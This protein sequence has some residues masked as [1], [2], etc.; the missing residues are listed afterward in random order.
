MFFMAMYALKMSLKRQKGMVLIMTVKSNII[1][2]IKKIKNKKMVLVHS[3]F[4]RKNFS[5]ALLE[6][7]KNNPSTLSEFRNVGKRKDNKQFYHEVKKIENGYNL[8]YRDLMI[9]DKNDVPKVDEYSSIRNGNPLCHRPFSMCTEFVIKS[10]FR[11]DLY[12]YPPSIMGE[13][14]YKQHIVSYLE[15]EGFSLTKTE[16]YD[17]LGI[18]NILFTYSTT[19]AYSLIIRAIARP[20]D[21][22]LMSAPNYGIFAVT[23]EILNARVE[24]VNLREEDDWY[25]NPDLVSQRIDEINQQLE[26]QFKGVLEYTPKVVAFLNINPHNPVGKVLNRKK[27]DI[28]KKLSDI[29]LKKGVFIIDDLIYRDLTFDQSDLAFPIASIPTYFNNTISILGLSKAYG[30]AKAK[31]GVIV[32]PI[33]VC[34]KICDEFF[35]EMDSMSVFQAAAVAGAFN[36]TN[37]RYKKSKRYFKK[38]IREYQYHLHLLEALIYGIDYENISLDRK[39]IK[40]DIEKYT[41]DAK[42]L[43]IIFKGCPGTEIRKN[44]YPESGFFAIVDFTKLKGKKHKGK[45][46][47][48][49]ADFVTFLYETTKINCLMGLNFSW[50][51]EEE[52]VARCNFA[53]SKE[54]LIHNFYLINKAIRSLN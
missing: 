36:G 52:I 5:K 42:K 3:D 12:Q 48:N 49:D 37:R 7:S 39:S 30:L 17:G 47:Q 54:N 20:E 26:Q 6:F 16:G 14:E 21:V 34:N 46:I 13:N 38:L 23:T 10:L 22:I 45:I 43:E 31:A 40:K 32:A 8:L 51:I 18:E 28:I 35:G 2:F 1:C 4:D 19:H 27:M 29:C 11:K 33:P 41:K 9:Y 44:T 53:I 25:I 50:P 15:R 24:V